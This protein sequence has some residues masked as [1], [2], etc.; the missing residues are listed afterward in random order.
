MAWSTQTYTILH[1]FSILK[2]DKKGI[3]ILEKG[4][5][6]IEKLENLVAMLR[7]CVLRVSCQLLNVV[8]YFQPGFVYP[9]KLNLAYRYHVIYFFYSGLSGNQHIICGRE[10]G[11]SFAK[12]RADVQLFIVQLPIQLNNSLIIFWKIPL[13]FLLKDAEEELHPFGCT[14][15]FLYTTSSLTFLAV[16][17]DT[18]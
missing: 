17:I 10:S 12:S 13:W 3:K 4:Q 7:R 6:Y 8:S 11:L 9:W 1:Q 18:K 2:L 14:L 15:Y 16:P 5:I